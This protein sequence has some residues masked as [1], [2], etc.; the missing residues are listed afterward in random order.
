MIA[1]E[2]QNGVSYFTTPKELIMIPSEVQ[3][4]VSLSINLKKAT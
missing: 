4:G 3:N 2:V 1:S